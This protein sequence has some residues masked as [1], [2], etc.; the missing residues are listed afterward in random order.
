MRIDNIILIF[1]VILASLHIIFEIV[2]F[3]YLRKQ[4]N[5]IIINNDYRIWGIF[6]YNP[7]DQRIIV[8]KRIPWLGWTLN[9]ARPSSIIFIAIIIMI[10]IL[11][12]IK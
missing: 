5:R 6:Y 10:L 1:I 4:K 8:P 9:F 11:G 2:Q 7:D 3:V 12:M